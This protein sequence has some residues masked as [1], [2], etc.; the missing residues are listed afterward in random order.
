MTTFVLIRHGATDIMK[1]RIAGRMPG[2]HLN[3]AGQTQAARLPDRLRQFGIESVYS[4]PLERVRETAEPLCRELG[5]QLQVAQEFD[6]IDFGDWTNRTFEDLTSDPLW[7]RF[8]T[9]RS[10]TAPPNGE[11]M[12]EAQTRALRKM[13]ELCERHRIVAIVSH[14]D[15][16]RAILIHFLGIHLDLFFRI[17]ISPASISVVEWGGADPRVICVNDGGKV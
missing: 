10:S 6:E 11:L 16:L 12:L 13:A 2:I 7:Q 14:G 9:V 1:S 15:V 5:L 8:N 4:G 3:E 17:E